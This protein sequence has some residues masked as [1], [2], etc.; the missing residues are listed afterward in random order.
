MVLPIAFEVSVE[1][2]TAEGDDGSLTRTKVGLSCWCLRNS[3]I[4]VSALRTDKGVGG[5][6]L[7]VLPGALEVNRRVGP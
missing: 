3:P 6:S 5:A 1:I 2:G 7:M 4:S